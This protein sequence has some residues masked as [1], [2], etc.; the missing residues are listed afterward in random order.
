MENNELT[1]KFD[2]IITKLN[3]LSE[4][5]KA[6]QNIVIKNGGGRDVSFKRSQFFQMVYDKLFKQWTWKQ[7]MTIIKDIGVL[8]ALIY[9]LLTIKQIL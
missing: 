3:Q 8:A 4:D 1:E 5:V 6:Q 9:T 2:D 7:T